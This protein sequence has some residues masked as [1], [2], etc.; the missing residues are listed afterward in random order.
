MGPELGGVREG[1]SNHIAGALRAFDE[2]DAEV[3]VMTTGAS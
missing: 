2:L 3:R 1:R